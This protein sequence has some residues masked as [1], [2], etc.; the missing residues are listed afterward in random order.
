MATKEG[1]NLKER[2]RDP[3]L[4]AWYRFIRVLKKITRGLNELMRDLDL[5]ESQ[6][7]LLMRVA[8]EKGISQQA[9][10]DGMNVTKGNVTQHLDRLEEQGLVRRQ[11]VGR[12]NQLYLSDS[13]QELVERIM[14]V[15]D[16]YVKGIMS[17]MT[18]QEFAQFQRILRRLDRGLD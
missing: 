8:F 6:F 12:T 7:D 10:A 1:H 17:L 18:D 13:G 11:K 14:P 16:A 4:L 3:E 9:C 2:S 5:S 15:H